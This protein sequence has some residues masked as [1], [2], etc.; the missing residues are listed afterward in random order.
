MLPQFEQQ[1]LANAFN[2][3]LGAEG[4]AGGG[5]SVAAGFFANSTVTATKVAVFQCPSDEERQFQITPLYAGG[6]LSGPISTKGN[7]AV[8]WGNTNWR[9]RN[10]PNAPD[11]QPYL[12]SAFGHRSV[13]IA[14]VRDGTSNTVFISEVVQGDRFDVRGVMWSSIPGGGS[15]MSRFAPNQFRDYLN[16]ANGGDFLN[17]PIFCV[18]EARLPCASA[19]S[20]NEAFAASRSRHAGGVNVCLGDGSVRFI[21]ETVA[22]P[23]WLALNTIRGGEVISADQF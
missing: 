19:N 1:N 17:R 7:Y 5:L 6:A 10:V 14:D 18:P 23:I 16:L 11:G 15:F 8:S 20:D 2:Y 3:E 21:K 13:K 4:F 12:Q 22:H 9:Q